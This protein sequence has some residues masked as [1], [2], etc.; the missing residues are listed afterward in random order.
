MRMPRDQLRRLSKDDP[1]D[2]CKKSRSASTGRNDVVRAPARPKGLV[3]HILSARRKPG[4]GNMAPLGHAARKPLAFG[5]KLSS[6][7]SV[8]EPCAQGGLLDTRRERIGFI[9]LGSMGRPMATS[10]IR[11]GFA[12]SA[13][14]TV[15]AQT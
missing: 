1:P 8:L 9:G 5:S 10:L 2:R 13:F 11:K 4:P 3:M 14:D 15:P 12:L 7:S 6:C